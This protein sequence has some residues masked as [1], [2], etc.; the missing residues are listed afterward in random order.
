MADLTTNE[1]AILEKLFQMGSGYVL[2]FSH[3][4][5]GEFFE[6]DLDINI[7]NDKFNYESG[8]KAN[9]MRGFWQVADNETVGNAILKLIDYIENQTLIGDLKEGDFPQKLIERGK[10]IGTRLTGNRQPEVV[11][12]DTTKEELLR[13]EIREVSIDSL[14][15]EKS[16]TEVLEQRMLEIDK[17][18]EA[19]AA[20]GVIFLC[21]ST[22][23]GI[24]CGI[25]KKYPKRFNQAKSSPKNGNGKVKNFRQWTLNDLINVAK[26]SGFVG[27]DVKKF[28]HALRG[29]RNYIHPFQQAKEQFNPDINTAKLCWQVL[30]IAIIEITN[31]KESFGSAVS[32]MDI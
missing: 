3:R 9:R 30:K 27:Q 23:E 18:F 15:L 20:L 1:K 16:I 31:N 11:S 7:Y 21:G 12:T 28:S 14:K 32:D 19:Q 17:S 6:N 25:A 5:M 22:L 26:E 29:F 8:S 4:T 2:N 10:E 13:K 24:L